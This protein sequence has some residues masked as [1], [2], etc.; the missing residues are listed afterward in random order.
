M[1]AVLYCGLILLTVLLAVVATLWHG[2]ALTVLWAWFVTPL[3]ALPALSLK[4]AVGVSLTARALTAVYRPKAE[5]YGTAT[6][7]IVHAAAYAFFAPAAGIAVGW[8]VHN[9]M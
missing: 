4:F 9:Y 3:F 2:Y 5:E 1:K 7:R 8:L 6:E